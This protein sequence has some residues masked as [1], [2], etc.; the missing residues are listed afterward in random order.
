M[1]KAQFTSLA[2]PLSGQG[3]LQ[4]IW[5]Q[6]NQYAP[7]VLLPD[8][9]DDKQAKPISEKIPT[10]FLVADN[11]QE[12]IRGIK[13]VLKYQFTTKQ[14]HQ[15]IKILLDNSDDFRLLTKYYDDSKLNYF[16]YV[17]PENRLL[18]VIIREVPYSI[19]EDEAK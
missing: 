17:N 12:V 14:C 4:P 1:A 13:K 3:A 9:S 2:A 16:T 19:R 7:L 18:S 5:G 8:G 15:K 10:I 6:S 11:Y